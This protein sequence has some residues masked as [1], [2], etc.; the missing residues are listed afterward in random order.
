MSVEFGAWEGVMVDEGVEEEIGGSLRPRVRRGSRLR[1]LGVSSKAWAHSRERAPRRRIC[2]I[3]RSRRAAMSRR[4][5]RSRCHRR[6][7]DEAPP[8]GPSADPRF[9]V[10]GAGVVVG[11]AHAELDR[12]PGGQVLA[13][14]ST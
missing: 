1:G 8:G 2:S 13:F 10:E 7:G 12:L 11:G 9:Q 3:S 4:R 6:G 14:K 5:S